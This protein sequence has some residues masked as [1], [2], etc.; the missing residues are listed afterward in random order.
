[1]LVGEA[2]D[3]LI[4]LFD[5]LFIVILKLLLLSNVFRYFLDA[6]LQLKFTKVRCCLDFSLKTS[7]KGRV[8]RKYLCLLILEVRPIINDY[9]TL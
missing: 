1:M 6:F 8:R 7:T 4:D 9:F 2:K 5:A 3:V